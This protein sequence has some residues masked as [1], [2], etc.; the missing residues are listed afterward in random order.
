M[1]SNRRNFLT[2]LGTAASVAAA[3][4]PARAIAAS[5]AS[6]ETPNFHGRSLAPE[7][8]VGPAGEVR[9]NTDQQVSYTSCLGCTTQCGVRVR[10]DRKTGKVL[11]VAGN[12]YHPLSTLE[13]L[14]FKAS[15]RDSFLALS[16]TRTPG[17]ESRATA[18]GRG[19]A[20]V[21]QMA[22]PHRVRTPL[23]RVGP[24]GSGQWAPIAFEQLVREVVEGGD[25]FGEG[26]V[27]GLR[28]LRDVKTPIDPAQPGLGPKANQV[29]L[30]SS[31]NDG[32]EPFARRF[33]QQSFGSIN[34]VGHG[35]YCGGSYRSAA[36]AV[37]GNMKALAH[38]KPD[39]DNAEFILF[40]GTA[41]GNAGNP[42]KRQG[43]QLAK[44]RS[45]GR[46][47]YVV[48]DPVLTHADSHAAGDRTHWL[49]IRPGTDGALAM[50]MIR[51]M[52]DNDRCDNAFLAQPGPAAAEA[53]GEA[54]WSNA[55]HLVIVEP[56]HARE[57]RFLRASDLAALPTGVERYGDKDDFLALDAAS[58]RPVSHRDARAAARMMVDTRL[59]VD[60]KPLAVKS[61]FALLAEAA[62]R[63]SIDDYAAEC[64]VSVD[65][66]VALARELT[67]HGKRA[68][69][70]VHGGTMSGNGFY[71]AYGLVMLNVLVGNV[72]RKGGT[73]MGGG[74]FRDAGNGPRYV[75]DTF[76]GEVKVS[77]TP[78]GRNVSYERSAEFAQKKATG[79][80]YPAQAP[81]YPNA[82]Q[83][84]TEWFSATVNGYP[85]GLKAL[86]LWSTNP[87]YGIP[88][89]RAQ[90]LQALA[91][92]R[93]LPLVVA[94][95]PFINESSAYADY[96]VPDALL[97]ESWGWAAPWSGVPTRCT[98]ARWPVVEP[99]TGRT[100]DGQP[101]GIEAL[102]IALAKAM[103]LPG[104]GA[105]A[106]ADMDGKRYALERAEDWYLRGG[107]NIAFAGKTPVPPATEEDLL[108]SGVARL[109]SQLES[110]LK[111]DEW[112]QVA[113]LLTRGGRFQPLQEAFS[114]DNP[115]FAANRFALALNIY[116][117][118][119]G[120]TRDSITGQRLSGVPTWTPATFSDGTL[121]RA[122]YPMREWPFLMMSFKSP[123]QS[124]YSIGAARLRAL[125]PSNA[126]ALHPMDAKRFNLSDGDAAV[127]RTPAGRA[128]VVVTV[129][130][131][132][133][134][135]VLAV[136]HGF[137]HRELGA[138]QHR[139]GGELQPVA[140]GLD[141]GFNLN[142]LGLADP[143]RA[144]ASIRPQR[145]SCLDLEG[146]EGRSR[147]LVY[148]VRGPATPW[149][150]GSRSAASSA[151][152][153]TSSFSSTC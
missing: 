139:I 117:E 123:L 53:A 3:A 32:R 75:L 1:N 131:G 30:L 144:G 104:F 93:K 67:S 60:G 115:E 44:G 62:R 137:G 81:W 106:I 100:A 73:L 19:N 132:V 142:D 113:A 66:I 47:S 55:T 101:I 45:E 64:G 138:R 96:I 111:P 49:P 56:G 59:E 35:S 68:A 91:D 83:L 121:V 102:F 21:E 133:M 148:S 151:A 61:S 34:F 36:G 40:V 43:A 124:A 122:K 94:I 5:A 65:R 118:P 31:V 10:I 126:V 46:L 38:G 27:E 12:P 99:A 57:G 70:N 17:R 69:V 136:E 112:R 88:G 39:F 80:P 42:F 95:D 52:I 48:V 41:P 90:A 25:L 54:A 129:R 92:P 85:Y 33:M 79:K 4:T 109:R 84:S 103:A 114:A 98:T 130:E 24:R 11:R 18:C 140:K 23:K 141:A 147:G 2:D 72:N 22:S 28:A 29:A 152:E 6:A 8:S 125:R 97:Y 78:I 58:G 120:T 110:T 50:A 127:L 9:V 107:A 16:A 71:N 77:G 108:L 13:P 82:P 7:F 150:T 26:L 134:P 153:C 146:V 15:I 145:H 86:F 143:T 51:W 74:G 76:P 128:R 20:M 87:V 14:P 37:F 135:G 119:L 116:H 89:L 149:R 63:K 105:E